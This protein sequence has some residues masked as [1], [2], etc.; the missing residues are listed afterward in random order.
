MV[1]VHNRS[2]V[3]VDIHDKA[4]LVVPVV[5]VAVGLVG[6]ELAAVKILNRLLAE[7]S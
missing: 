5:E 7:D 1:V 2:A 3:V 6:L 4:E